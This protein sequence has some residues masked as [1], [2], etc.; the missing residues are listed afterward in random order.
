MNKKKIQIYDPPMCCSSGVCGPNVNPELVRFSS[1]LDWLKKQNVEVE[2]FNLSSNPAAFAGN[3]AVKKAL[4]EEGNGCLPLIIIDDSIVSRNIYPTRTELA[5][6]LG[7]IVEEAPRE[8]SEN[9]SCCGPDCGC[10]AP[11]ASGKTKVVIGIIVFLIACGIFAYKMTNTKPAALNT[12]ASAFV[13]GNEKQNTP[14]GKP[15]RDKTKDNASVNAAAGKVFI[16]EYLESLN[17]LNKVA[18]NHG[19]VFILIPAK[20]DEVV[21]PK[22]IKEVL[23]AQQTLKSQGINIGL[24]TLKTSAPDYSGIAKQTSLPIILVASKGKG[25]AVLTGEVT[26]TKLMQAFVASSCAGGCGPSECGPSS[27]GCK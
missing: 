24:Y 8:K 20:K 4:R 11:T 12:P 6:F 17:S 7:I 23:A 13:A 21:K 19:V 26:Q 22:T 9:A 27:S 1:D 5:K 15:E 25:M 2:R 18:V 14:V 16:G 10:G 3:A